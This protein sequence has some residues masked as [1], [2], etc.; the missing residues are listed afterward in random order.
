[1]LEY[2]LNTPTCLVDIHWLIIL[3]ILSTAHGAM[4]AD[5]KP[6]GLKVDPDVRA[7]RY[8]EN[9]FV[10][11]PESMSGG[12]HDISPEHLRGISKDENPGL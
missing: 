8:L 4:H 7:I 11:G 1:M 2:A 5:Y 3:V 12:I 6:I 10:V 9:G